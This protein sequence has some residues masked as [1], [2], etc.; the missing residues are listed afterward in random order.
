MGGPIGGRRRRR[1][2]G[3]E[4]IFK[5]AARRLWSA[6]RSVTPTNIDAVVF[7][8]IS[9]AR[10]APRAVAI[11]PDFHLTDAES[12]ALRQMLERAPR[13]GRL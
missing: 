6:G 11:D 2:S 12:D 1:S 4:R 3:S 7:T 13:I 9:D 5:D 10:E 8:C